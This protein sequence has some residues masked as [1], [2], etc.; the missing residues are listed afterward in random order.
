MLAAALLLMVGLASS[1]SADIRANGR[2]V[3]VRARCSDTACQWRIVTATPQDQDEHV[4]AT[5]PDGVF[6]DHFIINPSPDGRRLAFMANQK[7]WIMNSDGSD[8]HAVFAPP[9]DGTGVDDSPSFTPDGQH[10][11][12]T[13]CCPKGFGYS[14]WMISIRG[15][16]L[17]DITK[18]PFQHGNGPADTTP[19]VS[20]DGSTG[21]VQPLLLE[22][23]LRHRRCRHTH[24]ADPRSHQ[25]STRL[26]TAKLVT[27]WEPDCVRIP[28]SRWHDQHRRNQPL[29][30]PPSQAH[31]RQQC[32]ELRR[33]ILPRRSMDR[34]LPLPRL[35]RYAGSLRHAAE[36]DA[37]S[38]HHP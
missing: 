24:R 13:R 32:C 28:P 1:A 33:G 21:R 16:H 37:P 4:L 7:I 2:I 25:P 15:T 20:P 17:R 34:L 36:W 18:E 38:R 26:P 35:G 12:F 14:L 8:L 31:Q 23:A 22:H 30:S 11:V 3:F 27:R 10:L 19:Q 9:P 6:D 5:F 29:G